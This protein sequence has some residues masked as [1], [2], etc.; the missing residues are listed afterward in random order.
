MTAWSFSQSTVRTD[1]TS[2][3]R[4]SAEVPPKRTKIRGITYAQL[5]YN[6]NSLHRLSELVR[7]S[8]QSAGLPKFIEKMQ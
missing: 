6:L 7:A 1:T 4:D 5:D 8:K 3:Q 2:S